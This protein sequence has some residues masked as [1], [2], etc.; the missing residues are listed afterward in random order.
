MTLE[1]LA[2]TLGDAFAKWLAPSD[3]LRLR[4]ASVAC[5]ASFS[6]HSAHRR[7]LVLLHATRLI[8][9][10]APPA[11]APTLSGLLRALASPQEAREIGRAAC[12]ERGAY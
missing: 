7:L 4:G 12:R 10:A 8:D 1:V 5:A 9:G 6:V 11:A 2:T 3:V